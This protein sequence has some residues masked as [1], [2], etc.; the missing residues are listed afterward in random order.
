LA[1]AARTRAQH[2]A[3]R[4]EALR[5]KHG[6]NPT[7]SA[8]AKIAHHLEQ[9][10]LAAGMA[11][12]HSKKAKSLEA[13]AKREEWLRKNDPDIRHAVR[14]GRRMGIRPE[15]LHRE[16]AIELAHDR[17]HKEGLQTMLQDA[18]QHARALGTNLNTIRARN[19]RGIDPDQVRG[20]DDVAQSMASAYPEFFPRGVDPESQLFDLLSRG[21]PRRM[22][23]GEA[24][25]RAL[26]R[27]VAK[28]KKDLEDVPFRERR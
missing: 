14:E 7:S 27:L 28:Q 10:R 16:A 3:S 8:A 21:N 12:H 13:S 23:R 11:A 25:S 15:R 19:A 22:S 9:H 5:G 18:R 20:L 17:A 24:Y 2:H 26:N 1:T 4:L 6:D